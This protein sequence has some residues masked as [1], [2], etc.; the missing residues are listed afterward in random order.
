MPKIFNYPV[1]N[2]QKFAA[3][4]EFLSGQAEKYGVTD[5]TISE[6]LFPGHSYQKYRVIP[7]YILFKNAHKAYLNKHE[8]VMNTAKNWSKLDKYPESKGVLFDDGIED[9]V[10]STFLK[11]E[12]KLFEIALLYNINESRIKNIIYHRNDHQIKRT[13]YEKR[14]KAVLQDIDGGMSLSDVCEK[15]KMT[16][17]KVYYIHTRT[18]NQDYNGN[19]PEYLPNVIKQYN[20]GKKLINIAADLGIL[21]QSLYNQ[22][23]THCSTDKNGVMRLRRK[24]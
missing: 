2:I 4:K 18:R 8:I 13:F 15:Y 3:Y 14:N 21:K 23:K 1:I 22:V 24:K 20:S 17:Q 7:E 5:Q 9:K 19:V 11:G 6:W 16:Y 12:L 10:I